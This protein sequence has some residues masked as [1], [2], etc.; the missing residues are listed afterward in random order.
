MRSVLKSRKRYKNKFNYIMNK[1][2]ELIITT[3]LIKQISD[4]TE[5]QYSLYKINTSPIIV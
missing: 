4:K 1:N 2:T 3:T 5:V